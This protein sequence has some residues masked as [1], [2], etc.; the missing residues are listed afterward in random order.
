[1]VAG[2]PVLDVGTGTGVL[3]ISAAR[4]GAKGSQGS[5]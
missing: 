3:A 5:T 1:M 4:L 2:E